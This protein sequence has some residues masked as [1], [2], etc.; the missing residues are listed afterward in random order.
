MSLKSKIQELL[1]RLSVVSKRSAILADG[2][3]IK[4]KVIYRRD[5]KFNGFWI[6][7]THG[8]FGQAGNLFEHEDLVWF[9]KQGFVVWLPEYK[10]PNE[11]SQDMQ[12][13]YRF[14]DHMTLHGKLAKNKIFLYGVSRGGY[15]AAN[16]LRLHPELFKATALCVAPLDIEKW[17]QTTNLTDPNLLAYFMESPV[18]YAKDYLDKRILVLHATEDRIVPPEQGKLFATAVNSPRLQKRVLEGGHGLM[19]NSEEALSLVRD[20]FLIS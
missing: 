17:K 9:A 4:F 1:D 15:V 5:K 16:F 6:L 18:E 2:E 19:H 13:L 7:Y 10:Q 11:L 3:W 14:I 8:G 12:T 20:F